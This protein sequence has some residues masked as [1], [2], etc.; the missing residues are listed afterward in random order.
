MQDYKQ[1]PLSM[2]FNP[3]AESDFR[4]LLCRHSRERFAGP[5]NAIRGHDPRWMAPVSR[6]LGNRRYP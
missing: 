6:L 2:P 1:H 3:I 5:N 4:K